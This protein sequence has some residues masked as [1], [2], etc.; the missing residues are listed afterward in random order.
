MRM[1][2]AI[3]RPHKYD[4]VRDA[5]MQLGVSGVT[6]TQVQ[7]FGRQR[8]HTEFYRGAEYKVAEVP[9]I[10]IDVAVA[11]GMVESVIAAIEK[12][13]GSDKIGD[14]K[15]FVSG[16]SDVVRIRTGERNEKALD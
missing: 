9:K 10:R 13:A 6:A 8:G 7:G 4:Q 15:I 14:G 3:V 16:L 2:T 12:V 5:L 11:S 1:I